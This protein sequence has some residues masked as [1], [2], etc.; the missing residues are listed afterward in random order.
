VIEKGIAGAATESV[1]W[2]IRAGRR[3]RP[4]GQ[5]SLQLGNGLVESARPGYHRRQIVGK[6]RSIMKRTVKYVFLLSAS[7]AIA[8]STA[9]CA[10][11]AELVIT[12]RKSESVHA[13]GESEHAKNEQ[14]RAKNESVHAKGEVVVITGKVVHGGNKSY[15]EDR[16]SGDVFRFVG[17]R[18]DEA[19]A[20]ARLAGRIV[21]VRLRIISVESAKAINAQ[22][23]AILQ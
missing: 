16:T 6:R 22:L 21:R 23:I 1:F 11:F 19:E 5:A 15:L 20:L 18:K 7:I 8:L 17:L 14:A 13:K 9:G 12:P 4:S 10:M 2:V 3:P